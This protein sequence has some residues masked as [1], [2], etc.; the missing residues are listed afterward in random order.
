MARKYFS[1]PEFYYFHLTSLGSLVF[2]KT[3]LFFPTVSFL[4]KVDAG[5]FKVLPPL[6]MLAWYSIMVLGRPVAR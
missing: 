6:R 3:P 5:L 4:D 1:E 2:L